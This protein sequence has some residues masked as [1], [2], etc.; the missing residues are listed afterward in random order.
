MY[1]PK[2]WRRGTGRAD[3]VEVEVWGWSDSSEADA[4]RNAASRATRVAQSIASGDRGK[5]Y[6]Y[7]SNPLRE[8][9]LDQVKSPSGEMLGVVTR[10][11]YGCEVLN[12]PSVL[13]C[14][15][16]LEDAPKSSGSRAPLSHVRISGCSDRLCHERPRPGDFHSV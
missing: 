5:G 3:S 15:I 2:F 7:G 6:L 13:F 14:D 9:V 4:E 1:F 8:P 12:T 16:D 10:N 11:G